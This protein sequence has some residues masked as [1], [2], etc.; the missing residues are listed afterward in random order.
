MVGGPE[1]GPLTVRAPERLHA[2]ENRLAV[3]QCHGGRVKRHRGERPDLGVVPAHLGGPPHRHH[4]IGE[5]VAEPGRREQL[6]PPLGWDRLRM[7]PGKLQRGNIIH[8][9]SP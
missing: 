6:L 2:L 8:A 4:V 1:Q 7:L 5:D 3:M 9:N